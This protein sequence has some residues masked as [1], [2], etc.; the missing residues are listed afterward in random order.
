MTAAFAFSSRYIFFLAV[1]TPFIPINQKQ[2]TYP[3]NPSLK[4]DLLIQPKGASD[5]VFWLF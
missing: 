4:L 1:L 3:S 5:I 2:L